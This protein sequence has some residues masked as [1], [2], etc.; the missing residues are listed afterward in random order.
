MYHKCENQEKIRYYD[1]TSL[2]PFVQKNKEYPIGHP[3]IIS[4][5]FDMNQ[6]Y[7]GLVKCKILAPRELYIPVLPSRIN[8][9]LL[10]PLCKTCAESKSGDK[11]RHNDDQRAI[12]G[13][14]CTLEV[15]HALKRGYKIITIYEVWHY[16]DKAK[17]DR[18]L[19]T[20]GIFEDYVN[21]AL[22]EKQ[23]ASGNLELFNI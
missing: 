2:Y 17:Y 1:Y 18:L 22:K 16:R 7:F 9:K 19:N 11:C 10:F 23:E 14:W 15:D 4:E 20:K 13:T 12:D 8:G 5:N 21:A 3:E 6:N